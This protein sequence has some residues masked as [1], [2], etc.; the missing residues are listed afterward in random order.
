MKQKNR[1]GIVRH[2]NLCAKYVSVTEREARV[3][4]S[5]VEA[6]SG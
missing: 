2:G 5:A 3:M 4:Q 6:V 1:G